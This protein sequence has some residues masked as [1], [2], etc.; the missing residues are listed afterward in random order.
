MALSIQILASGPG[1]RVSDVVCDYGPHDHSFAEEHAEMAIAAVMEGCFQYRTE[2]GSATLVPGSLLLGNAGSGFECGHEHAQGDRCLAFHFA[3]AFLDRIAAGVPCVRK[4]AFDSPSVPPTSELSGL[5]AAA[6][7]A[8]DEYDE[9]ALE[10]VA[11]RLAG[12]ALVMTAEQRSPIRNPSARDERRITRAIRYIES[13]ADKSLSLGALANEAA[14]SPYHFLR[15][16]RQVT[17]MTPHQYVLR[18]RL[19]HAATALRKTTDPISVIAYRAGF[20]DLA[21][22]NRRFRRLIGASPSVYRATTAPTVKGA[23]TR[24]TP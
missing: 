10:E 18:T 11:T 24:R 23:P 2:T 6:E 7:A 19:H 15:T 5:L 4:T 22:F 17:G 9:A 13:L 1:W 20:K 8:R 21:S 14:M 3:P 16:F 12:A